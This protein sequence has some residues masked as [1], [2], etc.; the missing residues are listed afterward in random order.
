MTTIIRILAQLVFYYVAPNVTYYFVKK[1]TDRKIKEA[2]TAR[3][4]ALVA[5]IDRFSVYLLSELATK[6][7]TDWELEQTYYAHMKPM[8]DAYY[9]L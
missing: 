2:R 3:K 1:Y 4:A 8:T 5:D 7:L 9:A 6:G